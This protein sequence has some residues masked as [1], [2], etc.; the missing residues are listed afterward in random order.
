M[1]AYFE[2]ISRYLIILGWVYE[3]IDCGLLAY[4]EISADVQLAISAPFETIRL[5]CRKSFLALLF[6]LILSSIDSTEGVLYLLFK[7]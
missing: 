5:T 3:I 2:I 7:S 6:C 1:L 4:F